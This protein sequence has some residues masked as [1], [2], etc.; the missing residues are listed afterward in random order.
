M[1]GAEFFLPST[2]DAAQ[3]RIGVDA[4]KN[5]LIRASVLPRSQEKTRHPAG[6]P[7]FDAALTESARR[8]KWRP[9]YAVQTDGHG[10]LIEFAP[11][12]SPFAAQGRVTSCY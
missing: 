3:G 4:D 11:P 6:R 2:T 12:H 9:P 5:N 1:T 7:K 10:G 8:A